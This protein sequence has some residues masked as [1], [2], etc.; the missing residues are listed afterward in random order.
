MSY[1]LIIKNGKV[2]LEHDAIITDIAVKEG[3]IAAI[4]N[5]LTGAKTEI[6][7]SG[8]VVA[9]GMIDAHAHMS[10]TGPYPLGRV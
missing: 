7:A 1:D 9:P 2:V 8:M 3:K 6:D 4:G 5:G 10:E